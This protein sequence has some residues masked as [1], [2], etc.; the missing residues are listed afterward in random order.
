MAD[1]GANR[2]DP[3]TVHAGVLYFGSDLETCFGETLARLRANNDAFRRTPV[4]GALEGR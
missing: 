3:L 4:A 1:E 2:F